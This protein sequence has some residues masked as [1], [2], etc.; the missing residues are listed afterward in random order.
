MHYATKSPLITA[1]IK[2]MMTFRTLVLIFVTFERALAL[3]IKIVPTMR[4]FMA[5]YLTFVMTLRQYIP[6]YLYTRHPCIGD[7]F[8]TQFTYYI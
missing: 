7:V 6:L 2:I 5:F 3:I 4:T 8:F 1:L